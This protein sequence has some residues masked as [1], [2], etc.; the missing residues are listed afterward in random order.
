METKIIDL[1]KT[2]LKNIRSTE[3][4]SNLVFRKGSS[5]FINGQSQML[6]QSKQLFEFS[7]DDEFGDYRVAISIDENLETKCNCKSD[8]LCQHKIAAL[9]QLHEELSRSNSEPKATGKEYTREGMI[10]RVIAEREE[11]AKKAEYRIE[12]SDNIYGEH[13]L[14][15]EKSVEYKI[16]FYNFSKEHGYC[17]CPDYATNK[18]GTCKH[19]MY[20]FRYFKEQKRTPEFYKHE[21]P[22]VEIFLHPFKDYRIS[23]FY[24]G[25]LDDK[26]NRLI[27]KHFGKESILPDDKVLDFLGFMNESQEHKQILIRPGVQELVEKA[28]D[29]EMLAEIK[30]HTT[31]DFSPLKLELF[32]YQKEGI[33]F[34]TFK[35]GSIIADEMGLG[36]TIQ[37]IGTAIAKKEIFGFERTLVVCPASIKE[38]WKNEIERFTNEKATVVSGYPDAREKIYADCE[39]YF[40]IVNYE[41]VLRDKKAINKYNTDFIVL[42][43]AQR[44]KNYDTQ[45]SSAIKSLKKKH[46]LIITGTPIENRLIDLYSIVAFL[47]PGFLS[48][49]W[50]FSYQHCFFDIKQKNKITGYYNLQELKERLSSI[51]LR[52]EKKEVI[53]QLPNISHLD[54][55]VEMHPEQRQ[56]HS[57]FSSGIAKILRKKF[58][59]PFDMQRLMMLL[60]KMRMVCDSTY[61]VDFETNYSPKLIELKYVLFEKLDIYNNDK[62]IIIFSEWKRMNN[63]IAKMLRENDIGFVEL[64]GSV[65]VKKRGN[66]IKEFEENERCRVFIS[67]E[68]GGSGLNLQVAD[69]VINFELPWNPAKKNQRIGRI[70]RIGQKNENLTVIS[71]IT[72]DSIEEKIAGGLA[73]KQNLFDGVLSPDSTTEIV[74]FSEKGKSQFLKQL[75]EAIID[76]DETTPSDETEEK[77]TVAAET[78]EE[79]DTR[80]TTEKDNEERKDPEK[81]AD[82]KQDN[83]ATKEKT[84]KELEQV[85]NQ[86][87]GFLS[88]LFKMATG[89]DIA[90]DDKSITVD[91]ETGEVTMKFKLPV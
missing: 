20:A 32:P 12:Q 77:M 88:G 24:P 84:T 86:G 52:R 21:Y 27:F 62:K 83:I 35:E 13:I 81:L 85:M 30:E 8:E 71:F 68:A 82:D 89:K 38:Q 78:S 19:L 39:D 40:L 79:K 46:S 44:I 3:H 91:K 64:N 55:P 34:A 9:M 28:Y 59:T 48:P 75:E 4:V 14:Y 25:K 66:L 22:F 16:T 53:K 41:T 36:K 47:D 23:W 33:E 29:K 31:V 80:P 57:S 2:E 54:I 60:S 43:E 61:L 1:L 6:T 74:D 42:D 69:T 51:L 87:I 56:Y 37:A 72:K 70:D 58:I 63:I 49:L 45:T 76:I 5:L 67:T 73:L 90:M 50:E 7:V 15:N 18:L 11:K 26:L 17:S 65:P 10:K